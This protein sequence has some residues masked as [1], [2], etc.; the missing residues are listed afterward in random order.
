[1]VYCLFWLALIVVCTFRHN[2]YFYLLQI[3]NLKQH[4]EAFHELNK[5]FQCSTVNCRARFAHRV[6]IVIQF[7]QFCSNQLF[8]QHC[9][10]G[11]YG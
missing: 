7:V 1:M 2:F 9:G 8:H 3:Y 5:P 6:C 10:F 11:N 4:V